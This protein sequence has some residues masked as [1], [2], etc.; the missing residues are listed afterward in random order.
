MNYCHVY[1]HPC[2]ETVGYYQGEPICADHAQ[3]LQSHGE[4]VTSK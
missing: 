4:L 1:G 2:E 3:V